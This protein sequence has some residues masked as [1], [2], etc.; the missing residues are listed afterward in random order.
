[1][2]VQSSGGMVPYLYKAGKDMV[3]AS[4]SE[5]VAQRIVDYSSSQEL[6]EEHPGYPLCVDGAFFFPVDGSETMTG[7]EVKPS[8]KKKVKE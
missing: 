3:S 1:M 4:M 6:T 5:D 8:R 7:P 2:K